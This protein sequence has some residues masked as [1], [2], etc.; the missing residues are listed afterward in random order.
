M[1]ARNAVCVFEVATGD[2][3]WRRG[4]PFVSG[5]PNTELHVRF[6]MPNGNYDYII[7]YKFKLDA[8]LH[9]EAASSGFIQTYYMP[10]GEFVDLME[11]SFEWMSCVLGSHLTT[12]LPRHDD[13]KGRAGSVL[14]PPPQVQ[15]WLPTRPYFGF[16]S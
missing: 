12:L 15:R 10:P 14:L 2:V 13:R 16:Q 4:G 9:V 5:V 3:L 8:V 1:T 11:A 7:T 6:A